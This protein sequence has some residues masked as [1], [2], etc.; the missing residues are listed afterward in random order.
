MIREILPG[1]LLP[2]FGTAIGA[3]GVF[4][5]K[6]NLSSVGSHFLTGVAAGIMTAA[7]VWSLIIPAVERS[8][9]MGK[10]AFV[11]ALV[12]LA[13]GTAFMMLLGSWAEKLCL[14]A[15][16]MKAGCK[17]I[18]SFL[19]V[20][21]HN[22]PEG[23][24][25]GMIYAAYISGDQSVSLAAAFAFTLGIAIQNIP[26]GAIISMPLHAKGMG[27]GRSFLWGVLSGTVEPVGA[28]LSMLAARALSGLLPYFLSFAAGTMLFVVSQQLLPDMPAGRRLPL[29]AISFA[30]GF[31]VMMCLDVALS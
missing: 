24:A 15:V 30:V 27:K 25:V 11:P 10:F 17:E 18:I 19:A 21:I 26:E 13:A 20:T 29:R 23:M 2:F 28:V 12:G 5:L 9:A 8:E 7:S 14:R 3:L 22:F 4:F 6:K 31:A 16:H 1:I